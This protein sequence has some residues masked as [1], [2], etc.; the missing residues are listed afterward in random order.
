M[1]N[2]ALLPITEIDFE[3]IKTNLKN[4]L[5]T[6]TEFSDYDYEG[7]GINILLD[8]LAYNTH[9]TA[10]YANMLAAESFIDS[11]MLRKSVVSLAKN[12][13]Y[14]PFSSTSSRAVVSL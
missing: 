10:M 5:S 7:A 8:L 11:A 2:R 13:G 6:T 14:I 1:P 9:Y 4:Y 3:G 12:L